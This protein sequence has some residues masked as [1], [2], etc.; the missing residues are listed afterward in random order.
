MEGDSCQNCIIGLLVLNSDG[1][2]FTCSDCH[3]RYCICLQCGRYDD[4]QTVFCRFCK[5]FIC[6]RCISD[7][8][9][10]TCSHLKCDTDDL[11]CEKCAVKEMEKIDGMY[12]CYEQ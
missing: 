12:F 8:Y 6:D 1:K 3:A 10:V 7:G 11:I 4:V 5:K 2:S 9:F